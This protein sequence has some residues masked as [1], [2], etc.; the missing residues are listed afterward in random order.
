LTSIKKEQRVLWADLA[1]SSGY[2]DQAHF[3]KD[4]QI[5]AGLNPSEFL[6]FDPEDP[7]FVPLRLR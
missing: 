3:I 2:Y 7:R 6:A 1:C 4:F 5:F